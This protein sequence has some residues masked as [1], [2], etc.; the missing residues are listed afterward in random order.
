M[1]LSYRL[2][3]VLMFLSVNFAF[4]QQTEL[5][6]GIALYK[7]GNNRAAI[8]I[9][10]KLSKQK[11]TKTD[12]KVWNYLGLAYLENGDLKKAR[13]ALEK[14]NELSPQS[15]GIKTNLGY[16]YL[17][18]R[19][20]NDAQSQLN[21]AIRIEPQNFLAYY[22]RG[23][24]YLLERK[25]DQALTDAEKSIALQINFPSA[26]ILK[27]DVLTAQ[28]GQRVTNGSSPREEAEFLRQAIEVLESCVKNC[29]NANL[30]QQQERLE[31]LKV[32]YEY[33]KRNKTNNTDLHIPANADAAATTE[34]NVTPLKI[35]TKPRP[36][37]TDKARYAG[38]SERLRFMCFSAQTEKL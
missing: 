14:A 16:A 38:V 18:S 8:S 17:M 33:F 20:F 23:T 4:A 31:S 35:L 28:F 13:K 7:E 26:Y 19:K 9:L 15:S 27:A 1:K 11:E 6:K 30:Q 24:S 5:E 3:I 37:Y 32:F 36:N 25:F 10:E 21:E 12:A 29:Q 34:S 22:I 2:L